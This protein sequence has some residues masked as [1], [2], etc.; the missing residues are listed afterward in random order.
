MKLSISV[1]RMDQSNG[2]VNMFCRA[3]GSN[4]VTIFL[5]EAQKN[6]KHILSIEQN[7]RNGWI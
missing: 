4:L 7:V 3:G 6:L 5:Q 1:D 2:L